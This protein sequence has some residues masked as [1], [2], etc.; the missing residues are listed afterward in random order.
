MDFITLIDTAAKIV[1]HFFSEDVRY[2][3]RRWGNWGHL[4][5]C[6]G[7]VDTAEIRQLH[8]N[9]NVWTDQEV[10]AWKESYMAACSA[11]QVSVGGDSLP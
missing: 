1:N 3:E 8:W 6:F 2:R 4:L 7:L 10:R 9:I 5:A 11:I